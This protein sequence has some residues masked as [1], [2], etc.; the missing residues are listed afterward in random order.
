MRAVANRVVSEVGGA[1]VAKQGF[2]PLPPPPK[3]PSFPRII[4]A[5]TEIVARRRSTQLPWYHGEQQEA[6]SL[7]FHPPQIDFS[8]E[9][10]RAHLYQH[11]T[12]TSLAFSPIHYRSPLARI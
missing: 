9:S 5:L 11:T 8:A 3:S 1:A 4:R 7:L 12:T 6:L 10:D 2:R